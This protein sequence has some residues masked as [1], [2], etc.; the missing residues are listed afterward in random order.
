MC[1]G[2]IQQARLKKV[3]FAAYDPKC[4]AC[5][6]LYEINQDQRLNHRFQIEAGLLAEESRTLLQDFFRSRRRSK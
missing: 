6:T 5:G 3:F 1:A 2:A 4:G